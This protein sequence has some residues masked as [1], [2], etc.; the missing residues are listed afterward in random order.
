MISLREA[1]RKLEALKD[2]YEHSPV[3]K[4]ILGVR[5]TNDEGD[6][7]REVSEREGYINRLNRQHQTLTQ[8]KAALDRLRDQTYGTCLSCEE[9][10]S[11]KRLIAVPWAP[12]CIKCQE[13]SDR[14]ELQGYELLVL[15]A[16]NEP[17]FA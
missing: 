11:E 15:P 13:K 2:E 3:N 17:S 8:V 5:M 16:T 4:E 7:A 12:F 1:Q 9:P 14:D 6:I 10:I